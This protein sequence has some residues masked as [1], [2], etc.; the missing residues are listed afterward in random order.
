MKF[1]PLFTND[2]DLS[3]RKDLRT[4]TTTDLSFK[5]KKSPY[6]SATL[7]TDFS[8]FDFRSIITSVLIW[9]SKRITKLF[10]LLLLLVVISLPTTQSWTQAY[11]QIGADIDGE[12]AEDL[13]GRSV[14]LSSDGT[15]V[16]IGA[17]ENSENG[18]NRGHVRVYELVGGAWVQKGADIDGEAAFDRLGTS[19]S[20]SSDGTIVAIGAIGNDASGNFAGHVRVYEFVGGAWVQKGVDIDAEAGGDRFGKSVSLSSDGTIVAIGAEGNDDNGNFAG[21]VRVYEFVGGAWV[22]KG[23]DIDGESAGDGSGFSVSLSSDGTIVAIG[24]PENDGTGNNAGHVRVYEFVGGAWV[25]KGADIDGEAAGDES[26]I[27]VSLS[28]DGTTVAI[29][30]HLNDEIGNSAGHVRLYEFVGGAWV[31]KGADI[32]G[33]AAG[34]ESGFSVSL[35]SDGAIVAIGAIKND[36]NGNNVGHMRLYE[37]VGGAWVQ[38]GADIDG[39]AAGDESGFSVSL[40]SDGTIVAIGA[41]ENDGNGSNAGHVRVFT[42]AS[43]V[44]TNIPIP[45]ISEWGLLILGL[46]VLNM[47]VFFVQRRELI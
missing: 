12:V 4:T 17:P 35:S 3:C 44:V 20:L 34:D 6:F 25:Q 29:G 2:A 23:I 8:Y 1:M 7:P 33:E 31:Q 19:V 39:E 13:S 5:T 36:G 11:S 41:H 37:F 28:S 43:T 30:A 42:S 24:A 27:S 22:Q 45:T 9:Y 14:S 38:K 16:A 26:G 40:S 18:K 10:Q 32:D 47:S 21:H 15:I 46:L